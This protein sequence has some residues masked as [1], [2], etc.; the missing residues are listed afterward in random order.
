MKPLAKNT[1]TMPE[2]GVR[3]IMHKSVE[4]PDAIHLEVGQPNFNT[5]R[6]I[7]EAAYKSALDG[8][9]GYTPSA[10]LPSL[11]EAIADKVTKLN[12]I[13]ATRDN[14][15]VT[16]GGVGGITTTLFA[17]V[18]LDDEVMVPDPGWPNYSMAIACCGAR[19]VSYPC[20][21]DNGF[22]PDLL[23]IKNRITGKTKVIIV[24]TPANPSGTIYPASILKRIV[25]IAKK[26]DLYVISDE[27]YE[28]LVFEGEHVSAARFDTDGRVVSVYTFSKSYAMTGWRVGY[29]IASEQIVKLL[30]KIQEPFNSCAPSISQKAA[31]AALTGP[32][33]CVAEMVN[34]YRRRRDL[35]LEILKPEGFIKYRPHGTFY[36]LLDISRTK[37]DSFEFAFELLEK[38]HVGVAPGA[39]FGELANNHVRICVATDDESLVEGVK[40]FCEFVLEVE[41]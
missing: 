38:R 12:G 3:I 1:S 29:V 41:K 9:T 27:A 30:T 19:K 15:V 2:T 16:V 7:I 26:Y 28:Q 10:G 5:P 4:I 22:V 8:Y 18:D 35:A 36:M 40:R 6:H 17:L 31:E 23:D 39:T 24:N 14:V 13:K 25:E 11:R 32:Q 37:K 21:E 20:Y 33:D 34:A